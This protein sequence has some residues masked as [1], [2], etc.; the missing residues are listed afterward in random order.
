MIP[1]VHPNI[2]VFWIFGNAMP[3]RVRS[4]IGK[5]N[6]RNSMF[7]R[8]VRLTACAPDKSVQNDTVNDKISCFFICW[9]KSIE[10]L[11]A[12]NSDY[13]H[14]P[15]Q[16]QMV[17]ESSRI[18]ENSMRKYFGDYTAFSFSA[19]LVLNELQRKTPLY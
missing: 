11:R 2:Y 15:S 16:N 8:F 13:I 4:F 10:K 6:F 9:I 3:N 18:I 17:A 5:L 1:P 14:V 12:E 7:V 19:E